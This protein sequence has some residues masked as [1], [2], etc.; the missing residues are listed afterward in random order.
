MKIHW[1]AASGIVNVCDYT[2]TASETMDFRLEMIGQQ[3]RLKAKP[4][5]SPTVREVRN[6]YQRLDQHPLPT[7]VAIEKMFCDNVPDKR[8]LIL[9]TTI[10]AQSLVT[11]SGDI[12]IDSIINCIISSGIII[13]IIKS[14]SRWSRHVSQHQ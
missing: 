12:S 4:H 8:C 14:Q 13:I 7:L 9:I 1:V 2:Q 3:Y 6:E 11:H 5:G 10:N